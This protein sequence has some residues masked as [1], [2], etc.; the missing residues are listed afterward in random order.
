MAMQYGS[1]DNIYDIRCIFVG[2]DVV[3]VTG[4]CCVIFVLD[5]NEYLELCL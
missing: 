5:G 4:S 1:V 2:S 3:R